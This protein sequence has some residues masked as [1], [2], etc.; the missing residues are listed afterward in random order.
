MGIQTTK[1]NNFIKN[2]L[3]SYNNKSDINLKK[4]KLKLDLNNFYINISTLDPVLFFNNTEFPLEK[5]SFS[6]AIK[7]YLK[8][9]FGIKK[10][11]IET[12]YNKIFNFLN[13]YQSEKGSV[14]FFILSKILKKGDVKLMVDFEFDEKGKIN[15]NYIINGEIKDTKIKIFK[16]YDFNHLNFDFNIKKNNYGISDASFNFNNINFNSKKISIIKKNETI[17]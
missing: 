7:S 11:S 6:I 4:V 15:N 12:K 9:E 13:I 3:K 8:D 14:Q 10:A 5:L 17:K 2:E 1:F 16:D